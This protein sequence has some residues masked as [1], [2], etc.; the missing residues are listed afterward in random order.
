[1]NS[2]DPNF[3]K[4]SPLPSMQAALLRNCFSGLVLVTEVAVIVA[5]SMLT[6]IAYHEFVYGE[7]ERSSLFLEVGILSSTVFAVASVFRDDYEIANFYS[8]APHDRNVI[9]LWNLTLLILLVIFFVTKRMDVYSRGAIIGFYLAGLPIMP[10]VRKCFV[11][12]VAAGRRHGLITGKRIYV[13]GT[14]EEVSRLHARQQP[15][16]F[17]L[18]VIGST[19][20]PSQAGAAAATSKGAAEIAAAVEDVRALR[21]DAVVLVVPWSRTDLIEY[22]IDSFLNIPAEIHLG[23]EPILERFSNPRM[24]Q[25]GSISTLRLVRQ[26]LLPIEALGKRLFDIFFAGSALVLVMPLLAIVA[27]LIRLDSPGPVLFRQ[28]RYGFNQ[29]AFWI[30]KFRT[31]V[32]LDD[33]DVVPQVTV[34]DP[35]VTRLGRWLRRLNI[36]ELPQLLNVLKGEMSIV[37]PRPHALAHNREFEQRIALY[38]R[39]HNVKPG[40]TG[41]A[42]VNGLRGETDTDLKM[43]QRIDDDLYYIDNWSLSL[44]LKIIALTLLSPSSYRNAA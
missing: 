27:L 6:N 19:L 41:L 8:G 26:P 34:N 11:R 16:N 36:D 28:R 22:C 13:V 35:R 7:A 37:G 18:S 1:M 15:W 14:E 43:R 25:F 44:D 21:P 29:E 42:Q 23:P 12:V 3:V 40:I 9:G 20:L 30:I 4:A 31:M 2:I 5:L 33:G 38:A 17:G 39:R 24:K 10:L 32:T